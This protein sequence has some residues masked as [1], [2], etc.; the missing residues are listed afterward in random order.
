MPQAGRE[1]VVTTVDGVLHVADEMGEADLVLLA[2]P[3]HL[4]A[5]AIR[6]PVIW[7]KVPEELGDDALGPRRLGEE[8]GAVLVVEH[9]Q[10]PVALADAQ[11]G[12]VRLQGGPRQQFGADRAD[13]LGEGASRGLQHVDERAFADLQTE[14]VVKQ[15]RQPLE[16]DPLREA[17]ID[18]ERAQVFAERRTF[19]HIDRRLG[20][21]LPGAA[22]A[23]PAKERDAR[24]LR[25]DRRDLD[26]IIGLADELWAL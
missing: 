3:A 5:I 10:P 21:E 13:L 15:R 1:K 7:S 4:A 14:H 16:G 25:H 6:N 19:G 23:S 20:L 8:N 18:D 2:G 22:G 24:H 9:P 12:S 17:Q 26:V 11:A